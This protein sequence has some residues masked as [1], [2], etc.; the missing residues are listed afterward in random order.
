[1]TTRIEIEK[2]IDGILVYAEVVINY[3]CRHCPAEY[4]Q[5]YEIYLVSDNHETELDP[6]VDP[7]L[8]KLAEQN[9]I[10][11]VVDNMTDEIDDS[12]TQD[13]ADQAEA[14]AENS[15]RRFY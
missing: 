11:W 13:C 7:T 14:Y 9:I 10:Q 2:E 3:W 5:G 1:M 8:F 12:I 6:A 4:D 15:Y